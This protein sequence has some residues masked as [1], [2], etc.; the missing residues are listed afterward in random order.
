MLLVSVD[1]AKLC[2]FVIALQDLQTPRSFMTRK[3]V[4][5]TSWQ[6]LKNI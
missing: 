6:Q 4:C 1:Y 5:E 2:D 3:R